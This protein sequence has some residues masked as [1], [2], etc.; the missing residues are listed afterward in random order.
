ML[1]IRKLLITFFISVAG[2]SL[3]FAQQGCATDS[4]GN[5]VCAS[6][7]G[8]AA[9]NGLG[10]VVT[11][12]GGCARDSLGQVVCA[13]TPYGGAAVNGLG[14]VQTGRGQC[15]RDGLGQVMCSTLPGGGA[16]V[17]SLGQAVCAGGC[18]G[19]Y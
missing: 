19:G 10:Q 3:A 17:N 4:L 1:L 6:P 7:G 16:A 18:S 15:V 9:V 12:R 11:G 8:G 14:Q 13:Q 2:C 5:V